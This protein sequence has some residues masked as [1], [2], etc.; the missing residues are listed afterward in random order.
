MGDRATPPF[1]QG[2]IATNGAKKQ[3]HQPEGVGIQICHNSLM[4]R[5]VLT[6]RSNL[7]FLAPSN[8]YSFSLATCTPCSSNLCV[9][10]LTTWNCFDFSGSHVAGAEIRDPPITKKQGRQRSKRYKTGLGLLPPKKPPCGYCGSTEHTTSTCP[11]KPARKQTK[12]LSD[13]SLNE[14]AA[15]WKNKMCCRGDASNIFSTSL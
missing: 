4:V 7:Y 10:L 6:E 3:A 8:F 2:V 15:A 5:I 12:E 14:V 13:K 11:A 1:H 9:L